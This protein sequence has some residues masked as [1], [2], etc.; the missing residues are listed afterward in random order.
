MLNLNISPNRKVG[1]FLFFLKFPLNVDKIKTSYCS[2]LG[3]LWLLGISIHTKQEDI[4]N[5]NE[6]LY[7]MFNQRIFT[8]T[9]NIKRKKDS[10]SATEVI[11]VTQTRFSRCFRGSRDDRTENAK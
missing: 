5:D 7:A 3:I 10:S 6:N 11:V 2:F 8:F 9:L 1:I 4:L